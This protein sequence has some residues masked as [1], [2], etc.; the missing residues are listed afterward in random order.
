LPFLQIFVAD[1][2][3]IRQRQIHRPS[4]RRPQR[5]RRQIKHGFP[6]GLSVMPL[7]GAA[8]VPLKVGFTIMAPRITQARG[9]IKAD[10]YESAELAVAAH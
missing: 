9:L 6:D 4:S 1:S 7:L 5:R 3:R 2:L 10:H 8:P